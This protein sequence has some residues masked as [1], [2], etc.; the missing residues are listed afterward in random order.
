MYPI[1]G[2][3]ICWSSGFE[4]V[5]VLTVCSKGLFLYTLSRREEAIECAILSIAGFTWN[6]AA[7]ELLSSCI[8]DVEEVDQLLPIIICATQR[9]SV[10]FPA[11]SLP[12]A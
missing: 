10:V 12:V 7:W 3:S 9:Y 1:L 6:W 8:I 5:L 4:P 2:S 11:K